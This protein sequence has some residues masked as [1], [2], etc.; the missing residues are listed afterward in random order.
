MYGQSVLFNNTKIL[1]FVNILKI[2][3]LETW[4]INGGIL[5]LPSL[6][7]DVA[8]KQKQKEDQK[9]L[10]EAKQAAAKKGPMGAF[11]IVLLTQGNT[12]SAT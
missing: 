5:Y 12:L 2:I 4:D 8:F 6:Q 1:S 11:V 9:K 7:E 3:K 10:E